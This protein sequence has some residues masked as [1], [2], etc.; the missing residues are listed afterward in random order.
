VTST[1]HKTWEVYVAAAAF[2]M[3]SHSVVNTRP[4]QRF[5]MLRPPPK[6]TP[7]S[8]RTRTVELRTTYLDYASIPTT[9]E[10]H[11]HDRH[12]GLTPPHPTINPR[13]FTVHQRPTFHLNPCN[14][15]I[16]QTPPQR[17]RYPYISNT[18]S[19]SESKKRRSLEEPRPV[20]DSKSESAGGSKPPMAPKQDVRSVLGPL[21]TKCL[22]CN[23]PFEKWPAHKDWCRILFECCCLPAHNK[24]W[25]ERRHEFTVFYQKP[26]PHVVCVQCGTM[27][28]SYRILNEIW[29]DEE[30]GYSIDKYKG[31]RFTLR[32]ARAL[33]N[34][35]DYKRI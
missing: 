7:F 34:Y 3:A 14:T 5:T 16:Q 23:G 6:E 12:R 10:L 30:D 22:L 29:Y 15:R 35:K 24:C 8:C 32:R 26:V 9:S 13:T 19:D 28:K 31:E 11:N 27:G 33:L 4:R 25:K 2:I 17:T 1:T 20:G 18:M 21:A